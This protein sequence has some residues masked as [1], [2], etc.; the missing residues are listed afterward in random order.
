M[1]RETDTFEER[2]LQRNV[3]EMNQATLQD[4]LAGE[5]VFAAVE[6]PVVMIGTVLCPVNGDQM[7]RAAY[8]GFDELYVVTTVERAEEKQKTFADLPKVKVKAFPRE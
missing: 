6:I 7:I 4:W 5:R 8:L 3:L 1:G 2:Q